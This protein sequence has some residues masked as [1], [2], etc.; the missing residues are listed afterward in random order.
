MPSRHRGPPPA[1]GGRR[2]RRRAAVPGPARARLRLPFGRLP[3]RLRPAGD[4]ACSACSRSA[5][6]LSQSTANE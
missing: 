1:P 6:R 4:R 5:S 2:V 3:P